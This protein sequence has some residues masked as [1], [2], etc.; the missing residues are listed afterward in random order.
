MLTMRVNWR[1]LVSQ[2]NY[3]P[4]GRSDRIRG[5]GRVTVEI[6]ITTK[7]RYTVSKG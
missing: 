7:K 1:R 5:K 2:P 6:M 4:A 3:Q